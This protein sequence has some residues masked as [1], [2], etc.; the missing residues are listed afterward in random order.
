VA[1]YSVVR[2]HPLP[3]SLRL[4]VAGWHFIDEDLEDGLIWD[5]PELERW[6]SLWC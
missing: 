5:W 3:D 4:H 1:G 2:R 6:F